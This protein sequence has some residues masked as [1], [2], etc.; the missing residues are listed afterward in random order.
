M[1]ITKE[2]KQ[3][4]T[5][6][7]NKAAEIYGLN[8]KT[9]VGLTWADDDYIQKLNFSYRGKNTPT[10]VLSFAMNDELEENSAPKILE[11]PEELEILL[12]DI[13]IS[14]ETAARQAEVYG[15]GLLREIA[16]L[17]IH[18]MLHLLGYDHERSGIDKMHMKDREERVMASLGFS[19]AVSYLDES[20]KRK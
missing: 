17:I 5:L 13:V 19:S 3:T 4:A 11:A 10:D 16:F 15:H 18:G 6:V 20:K 2:M 7:L 12:G 1:P 9:E 14:L 8:P